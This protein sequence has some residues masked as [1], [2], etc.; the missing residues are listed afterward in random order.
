LGTLGG[1]F[2]TKEVD[3]WCSE[4]ALRQVDKNP[5]PLKLVEE[6]PQMSFMF[7]EGPGENQNVLQVGVAEVESPQNVVHE[8]LEHLAALLRSKDM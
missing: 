1:H 5:V 6:S 7:L 3:L 8:V 4:D 2:V